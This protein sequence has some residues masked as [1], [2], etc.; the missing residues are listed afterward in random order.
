MATRR[1]KKSRARKRSAKTG[2][3]SFLFLSILVLVSLGGTVYFIFLARPNSTSTPPTL[4]STPKVLPEAK[5]SK[6]VAPSSQ[7]ESYKKIIVP[8]HSKRPSEHRTKPLAAIIIDD[9]GYRQ[10]EGEKLLS[11]DMK[12][13]FAFLPFAPHA[14]S[15]LQKARTRGCDILLHLPMEATDPKWDPGPGTLYIWMR[16]LAL[17]A[18]LEK[19]LKA[20]PM[21]IGINNHMGSRFSEDREAMQTVLEFA[22]AKGLF[23]M[24]SLTSSGSVG[25][26]LAKKMGVPSGTRD[27]FLDNDADKS[28]IIKQLESF[29]RFAEKHGEAIGIAH[30]KKET[31]AALAEFEGQ[32]KERITLVGIHTLMH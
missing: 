16:R 17:Q 25:H 20:V 19:D 12:L 23:Y 5:H 1:T 10:V 9:M 31:I 7:K 28:K 3:L 2:F 24:D 32:F 11:L 15:L 8:S 18:H 29:V 21:A 22:R 30:P 4:S 26:S 13:S 6:S 27:F 14:E